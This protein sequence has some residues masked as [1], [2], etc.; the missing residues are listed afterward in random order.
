MSFTTQQ[1]Q[2]LTQDVINEMVSN[3]H[4]K[5]LFILGYWGSNFQIDRSF[6]RIY[7]NSKAQKSWKFCVVL[8]TILSYVNISHFDF[9]LGIVWM[10]FMPTMYLDRLKSLILQCHSI[11]H[12]LNSHEIFHLDRFKFSKHNLSKIEIS[13]KCF[14][15]IIPRISSFGTNS[16]T[17]ILNDTDNLIYNWPWYI[18]IYIMQ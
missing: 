16:D 18:T 9:Y 3:F 10:I 12:F 17:I 8:L 6:L 1:D 13:K 5:L 14:T 7:V 15:K 4:Y 11:Q 2:Q